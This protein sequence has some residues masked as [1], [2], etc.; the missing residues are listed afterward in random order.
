[1]DGITIERFEKQAK[2]RLLAVKEQIVAKLKPV[3]RGWYGY[4]KHAH[5]D[6][7]REMDGWVRGRL[8]GILRKRRGGRGRGRGSDHH[9]WRNR[10]FDTL[11]SSA[12]KQPKH[13]NGPASYKEQNADWK[14]GCG[15]SARPVWWE[16]R[17]VAPPFLPQSFFCKTD[18]IGR[19]VCLETGHRC[20]ASVHAPWACRPNAQRQPVPRWHYGLIPP[21]FPLHGQV[22]V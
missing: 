9:R 16:G 17:G 11:G 4:F 20:G 10:Y 1:M 19:R 13:G 6:V 7:L 22:L 5:A 12:W 3:L 14:V 21:F 18:S 2:E 8:R 15:K